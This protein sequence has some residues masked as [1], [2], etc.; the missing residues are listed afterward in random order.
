[1]N[2]DAF[3]SGLSSYPVMTFAPLMT[4]SPL[5]PCLSTLPSTSMMAT[6]TPVPGPTEPA[7]RSAG[8]SGFDAIWWAASVMP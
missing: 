2:D 6:S 7:F 4:T 1:M 5:A 3:A 8:G